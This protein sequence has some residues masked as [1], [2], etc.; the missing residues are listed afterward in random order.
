MGNSKSKTNKG[1]DNLQP[2]KH[3]NVKF[4][5]TNYGARSL[6]QFRMWVEDC[7]FPDRGSF[8]ERQ[9]RMLGEALKEYE[10]D[11]RK[12]KKVDIDWVAFKMWQ[13]ESRVRA[14]RSQ[15][16]LNTN[17]KANSSLQCSKFLVDPDLDD[18]PLRPL[19]PPSPQTPPSQAD[20]PKPEPSPPEQTD[21]QCPPPP[22]QYASMYPSLEEEEANEMRRKLRP[23]KEKKQEL[24]KVSTA[25]TSDEEKGI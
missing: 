19:V 3:P 10:S 21:K 24:E 23:R 8:S 6:S 18:C 12:K 1:E 20:L 16:P 17:T 14:Q 25:E 11:K 4:M 22:P 5:L 7:G 2:Y 9:I 15:P 13:S